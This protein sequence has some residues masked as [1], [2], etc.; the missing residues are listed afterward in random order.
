MITLE[1]FRNFARQNDGKI[2][3]TVGG[4]A[5]FILTVHDNGLEYTP[6]STR[7]ARNQTNTMIRRI[8]D[9]YNQTNSLK[10]SD[11]QAFTVNASYVLSLIKLK[12]ATQK[13]P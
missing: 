3:R 6:L 9:L 5:K 10:T 13:A 4:Q 7:E 2:L 1:E 12:A 8:L 11:Y